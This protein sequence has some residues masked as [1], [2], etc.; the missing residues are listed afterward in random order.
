MKRT[1]WMII[2]LLVAVALVLLLPTFGISIPA[3]N[4]TLIFLVVFISI[5]FLPMMF[6]M[7]GHRRHNGNKNEDKTAGNKM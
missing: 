2:G 3:G 6:M 5:C 7:R 1:S 4:V